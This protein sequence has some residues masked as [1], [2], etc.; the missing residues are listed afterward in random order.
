MKHGYILL[1]TV[2]HGSK[3]QLLLFPKLYV[4][5]IILKYILINIFKYYNQ[6]IF[7]YYS[8]L[9][10]QCTIWY[11]NKNYFTDKWLIT[12]PFNYDDR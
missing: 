6:K 12:C 7:N 3:E 10:S 11:I 1:G 9:I 8:I 2:A 5:C 4:L